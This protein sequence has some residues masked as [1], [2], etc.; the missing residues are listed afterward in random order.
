LLNKSGTTLL[1]FPG[2][3]AGSY[4]IPDSVTNVE[5]SAFA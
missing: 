1:Q 2:G 4:T 5:N 3:K